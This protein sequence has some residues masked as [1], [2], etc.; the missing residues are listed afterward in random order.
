MAGEPAGEKTEKA[1][2]QRMKKL[3]KEGALQKSQD[4]SAWLGVGAAAIM[5]PMAIANGKRAGEDQFRALGDIVADPTADRAVRFLSDGLGTVLVTLLPVLAVVVVTAIVANVAQG[6]LHIATKK[7][8]PTFKQ[9]NLVKGLKKTFGTQALWQGVKAL[10][11]TVVIGVVLYTAIQGLVPVLMSAGGLSLSTIIGI[12]SGGVKKLVVWAV[13][14]G[15]LLAAADLFVVM[16]RNRKQTRMTKKEISDE[17]KQ[18]EGDPHIKGQRRARQMAMS[19]NRMIANVAD[20]DVVVV[21]PTHVA[22]ALKYTPGQGAPKVVATGQGAVA[23]RIREKAT[24][25]RVPM[26]H[27][28]PLARAIHAMCKVDD[29]I[30]EELFT[31]VAQVLAFVM[32]LK[33]RGASAGQHTMATPTPVPPTPTAAERARRRRAA[34]AAARA[35]AQPPGGE[36]GSSGT[37]EAMTGRETR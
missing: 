19:R 11:K 24:E 6:G 17:N 29:E 14:A 16:K 26:V 27:D 23:A 4:L 7:L 1:T 28:I 37:H 3:R 32:A 35:S 12:G 13:A 36:N 2:P 20:A 22:V 21:N 25:H 33:R 15:L 30:P 10:L 5:M 9:F 18:A 34:R 8:K 31:A